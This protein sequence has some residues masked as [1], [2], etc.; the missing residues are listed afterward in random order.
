M[1]ARMAL[2]IAGIALEHREIL[3][4]NKPPSMLEASPKGTVPV[5]VLT[6]GRVMDQ[7]WEIVRW[8]LEQN[9]PANWLGDNNIYLTEATPL[10]LRCDGEFKDAL[11]QYKYADRYP[12]SAETY[13]EQAIPFINH[14]EA[15]LRNHRYLLSETMTVADIAI[16]PFVRQFAHVDRQWFDQAGMP[17]LSSWLDHIISSPLFVTIMEKRALWEFETA[18]SSSVSINA[19]A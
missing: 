18:Q 15:L 5:L 16:V 1:R 6:D 10:V 8:A 14:L 13:R 19:T 2:H 4:K 11:D 9:D 17:R 12:L 3:L 7:S